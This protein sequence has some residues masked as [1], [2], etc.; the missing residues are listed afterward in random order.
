M[1]DLVKKILSAIRTVSEREY[2]ESGLDVLRES[3]YR[4]FPDE[5]N[6]VLRT[7]F[8]ARIGDMLK[9]FF[10]KPSY[11]RNPILIA[12]DIDAISKAIRAMRVLRLEVGLEPSEDVISRVAG[13]VAGNVGSDIALDIVHFPNVVGGARIV[14]QG[15]YKE[16]TLDEMIQ[17]VFDT[18]RGM[19]EKELQ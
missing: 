7:K 4:S 8:E 17:R 19:I 10:S 14:F 18:K 5:F 9:Q 13:W 1:E 12:A 3:L 2:M 6:A 11:M 15:K 16:N